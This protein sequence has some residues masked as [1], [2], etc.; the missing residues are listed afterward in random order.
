[1]IIGRSEKLEGPYLDKNNRTLATGGGTILYKGNENWHGVGH[2][3][4]ATFNGTDYLVYH[5]YDAND[6]GK[7]KLLISKLKWKNGWP[8]LTE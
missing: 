6:E 4:V 7:P 3:A 5:G 1:M 8:V 2:N